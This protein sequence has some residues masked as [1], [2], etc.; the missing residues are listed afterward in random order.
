M[1]FY[2]TK[3]IRKT[4]RKS[5]EGNIGK[6]CLTILWMALTLCSCMGTAP[7]GDAGKD[8][9]LRLTFNPGET[10][11]R[12]LSDGESTITDINVLVFNGA[13]SLTGSAYATFAG[14]NYTMCKNC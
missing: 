4:S 3:E 13:G 6:A 2:K 5:R 10:R 9:L 11:S 14:G 12:A 7:E 1:T 8:A